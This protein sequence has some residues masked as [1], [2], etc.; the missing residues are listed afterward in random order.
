MVHVR[1]ILHKRLSIHS[2]ILIDLMTNQKRI[3]SNFESPAKIYEHWI[4]APTL[5]IKRKRIELEQKKNKPKD[6]NKDNDNET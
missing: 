1:L 5:S 3:R 6:H 4:P 2:D